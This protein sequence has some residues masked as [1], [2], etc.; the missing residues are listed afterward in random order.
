MCGSLFGSFFLP[1]PPPKRD[2]SFYK[3]PMKRAIY[4]WAWLAVL[5]LACHQAPNPDHRAPTRDDRSSAGDDRS[6]EPMSAAP[7]KVAELNPDLIAKADE[8]LRTNPSAPFGSEFPF[9]LSG[10]KYVARVEQH[11]NPDGDPS[12]PQGQHKGITLYSAD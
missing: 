2:R 6:S 5:L 3:S 10:R 9:E 4:G 11:D 8:I 12:R 1:I 7:R